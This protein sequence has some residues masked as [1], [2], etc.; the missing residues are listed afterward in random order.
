MSH[1]LALGLTK[2][3]FW[4]TTIITHC[5]SMKS[6]NSHCKIILKIKCLH[7]DDII[8]LFDV[9]GDLKHCNGFSFN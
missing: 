5:K 6:N 3:A 2:R 7:Q 9:C 4:N 8:F 1:S